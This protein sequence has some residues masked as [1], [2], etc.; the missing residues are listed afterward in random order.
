MSSDKRRLVWDALNN[1]ETERVPVGFWFHFA[2]EREFYQGLEDEAVVRKNRD[3][4]LRFYETFKPDFVKL[5]SDG[6][7]GYPNA[8][9]AN[10][11][12]ARD[13]AKIR[14]IGADHPWFEK[15]VSL[16]KE[17]TAKFGSEVLTFYNIFGPA[18]TLKFSLGK[19]GD[20]NRAL[21]DLIIED[22]KAVRRALGVV[23]H[24]LALL[25]SRAI[26]EGGADGI[27]LS[28]QNI[29]DERI[30]PAV[31]RSVIAPSEKAV[32][33]A[34]NRAGKASISGKPGS[35][36]AARVGAANILHI[37][38]YEGSRNDLSLYRDYD[39]KAV[40]W[41]VTVEGVSLAE[42]KRLF[43][44]KAVIGGFANGKGSLIHAGTREAVEAYT[45]GLLSGTGRRGVIVGADCTVPSDI[46]LSRL[47]WVRARASR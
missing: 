6:F 28:V 45:D 40:N 30:S 39:A 18:T 23:A 20:G 46:D 41:A 38:G 16:I 8:A 12:S 44:D 43:G 24:D 7:F 14:P 33:K 11:K 47:E 15:Q 31:Y 27:Y 10:A 4:H 13:L 25:A 1:R 9:I 3:G 37:C 19:G 21:A 29:Q 22:P 26:A 42:G 2:G 17:L 32:L 34:A 35:A 36:N 5:M